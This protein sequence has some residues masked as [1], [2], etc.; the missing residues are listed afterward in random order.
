MKDVEERMRA[1]EAFMTT[2]NDKLAA[3]TQQLTTVGMDMGHMRSDIRQAM[4]DSSDALGKIAFVET[5]KQTTQ[6]GIHRL[7]GETVDLRKDLTD[8]LTDFQILNSQVSDIGSKV[9]ISH[10]MF[11]GNDGGYLSQDQYGFDKVD[12][13]DE[14]WYY[15]R[16]SVPVNSES[17]FSVDLVAQDGD[18]LSFGFVHESRWENVSGELLLCIK[19]YVCRGDIVQPIHRDAHKVIVTVW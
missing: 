13:A 18:P 7:S 15:V 6:D 9:P 17:L 10:G 16:F 8:H 4:T 3:H 1:I 11:W 2:A 14:G 19:T 5:F 12:R